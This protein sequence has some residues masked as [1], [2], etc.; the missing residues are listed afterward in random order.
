MGG[1][2]GSCDIRFNKSLGILFNNPRD[3]S[4]HFYNKSC[5]N[6]EKQKLVYFEDR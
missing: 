3:I 1:F 6:L 5:F 2:R 4:L